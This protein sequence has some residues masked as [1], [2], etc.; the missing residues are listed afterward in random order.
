MKRLIRA[1]TFDPFKLPPLSPETIARRQIILLVER[2]LPPPLGI[3][4]HADSTSIAFSAGGITACYGELSATM[5]HCEVRTF[6]CAEQA[7]NASCCH[8]AIGSRIATG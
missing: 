4:G 6:S 8:P 7:R 5:G 2:V 3:S 1:G